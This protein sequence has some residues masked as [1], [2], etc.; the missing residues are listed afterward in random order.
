VVETCFH[1]G[2]A[3]LQR[4]FCMSGSYFEISKQAPGTLH[5]E[6]DLIS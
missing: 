3:A 6:S 4:P 2:A 5:V 1:I